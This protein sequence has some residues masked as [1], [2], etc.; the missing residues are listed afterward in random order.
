[1]AQELGSETPLLA[2][3]LRAKSTAYSYNPKEEAEAVEDPF[4][5]GE[6]ISLVSTVQ[7][8]NSARF[9]IFGS[10][11][12]LEDT[13][14]EA[15]IKGST[16]ESD[17]NVNRDFARQ[18]SSWTF[19]ES[20]VLKVGRVEH[21]LSTIDGSPD[22]NDSAVQLDYISPTIYRIKNDVVRDSYPNVM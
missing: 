20:G 18:V 5:V 2:P 22:G 8:R 14:F 1:M 10:A 16:E 4:I 7:A 13:W 6:Q 15:K 17:Q 11:E 12:A 19:Q 21:H 3:I 9:T